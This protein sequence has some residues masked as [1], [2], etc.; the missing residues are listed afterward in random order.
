MADKFTRVRQQFEIRKRY[1]Y[2]NH[3]AISPFSTQ[4]ARALKRQ[5]EEQALHG[6]CAEDLWAARAEEA[7]CLAAKLLGARPSE[8]AFVDNTTHGLNFFARGISWRRGDNVVLPRVEFPANVYP[9]LSLKDKGVGLKFVAERDGKIPIEAVAAAVDRRTRVVA[10]SF[11]EFSS[12]Y[13]NNLKALGRLCRDRG[14]YLVVDGIQGVGALKLDVKRCLIDGLSCGGH[15]WL[16]APQG[17][18]LFYC[19]S[20]VLDELSHP[21]PGWLSVVGWD[22]YY[23]FDYKLFP[24]SRR[25][26]AAQK[27]FLG[28]T[29]LLGALKII[30]GLGIADIE[31]RIIGLTDHL[32]SLLADRGLR[33]FSPR[34]RGEKSGIVSFFPGRHD[35]DEVCGMLQRKGFIVAARQGRIRVSPHFYNS[36]GEIGRF[37]RA[38]P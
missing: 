38:L 31:A 35:P 2:L 5:V 13:R 30:N 24:D 15:K 28:I 20:R 22:D 10:V 34:G 32:C 27:N 23:R 3:A 29:G 26:E 19:S 6:V 11:V 17:T 9:W 1:V 14:C 33:V 18:G 16:M 36:F 25:Y 37:V 12:G 8:I 21:M 4:L 7:R